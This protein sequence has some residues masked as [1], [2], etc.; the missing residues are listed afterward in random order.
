MN[1]FIALIKDTAIV[2]LVVGVTNATRDMY[3]AAQSFTNSTFS[4]TPLIGASIGYLIITIPLAW[5]VG[6]VERRLR[7]GLV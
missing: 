7:T 3:T 1:E 2:Y 4:P 5:L 6:R